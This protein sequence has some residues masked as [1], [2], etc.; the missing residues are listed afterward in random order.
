L[1]EIIHQTCGEMGVWIESLG[2]VIRVGN[3]AS[4]QSRNG[5]VSVE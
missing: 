3:A 2:A 4:M 5:S 1:R